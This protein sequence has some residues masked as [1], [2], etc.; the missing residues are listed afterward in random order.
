M[1]KNDLV[2]L[3]RKQGYPSISIFIPTFRSIPEKLQDR[4][5][6]KNMMK[7]AHDRLHKEFEDR[8]IRSTLVHLEKLES[9]IDYANTLDGLALFAN[10]DTAE[11]ITLPF[12]VKEQV[13]IDDTFQTRDLQLALNRTPQYW[14]LSLNEKS[15]RLFNGFGD[16]LIEMIGPSIDIYGKPT[17]GFPLNYLGPE[18]HQFLAIGTGDKDAQYLDDHLR[19]Y[20]RFVDDFFY[21]NYLKSNPLPVILAGTKRTLTLF[22]NITKHSEA[23][24]G[25]KEGSFNYDEFSPGQLAQDLWPTVQ[26][27][28]KK[29]RYRVLQELDDAIGNGLYAFS[30]EPVWRMATE[31][32]IY[33]LLVEK[34]YSQPG[35]VNPTNPLNI[36]LYD[37]QQA[38]NISDDLV[39]A[40][41]EMTIEK[42]GKVIFYDPG[43]LTEHDH[44]AA[45]L[46]Y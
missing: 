43:T 27:F 23:F 11:V 21:D 10:A 36:I 19:Q 6:V 34:N 30:L 15:T 13:I 31:G 32:R 41:I 8:D 4:I 25:F 35:K 38:E 17:S 26:E 3:Q 12:P 22:Q 16:T 14:V 37:N 9:M 33:K 46:R 29:E 28:L 44:I 5:R 42:N 40:L 18:E 24:V 20:Y 7:E 1:K 45:I 2:R 39:D